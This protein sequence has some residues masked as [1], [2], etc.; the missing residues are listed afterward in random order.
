ML[1]AYIDWLAGTAL[2]FWAESGFDRSTGRFHERLDLS[3]RPLAVP[4]RAMVQARQIYV[5]A[6]AAELGW[7]PT[8]GALAEQA[9]TSMLRDFGDGDPAA[10]FAFS[11]D[12]LSGAIISATR[13]AY[14]HAFV[15]FALAWLYRRTRDDA[16]LQQVDRTFAFLDGV[17]LD[18]VHGGLFDAAPI[19]D[20]SKR[21]NPLMHLL[22]AC[23]FLES[24]RPDRGYL[25]RARGIVDVLR[26]RLFRNP[27]GVLLEYF[28]EDWRPHPDGAKAEVWEPGHHMEWVWLLAKFARLA[29]GAIDPAAGAL[30]ARAVTHGVAANG[31]LYDEVD[32][33]W[34]PIK[35]SHRLWPH[36][37]AIKAAVTRGDTTTA[38]RMATALLT[39][40]V[41]KPFASGWIDQFDPDGRPT[42]DYVPASSL[43]HLF[44]AGA[45]AASACNLRPRVP[46]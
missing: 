35:P 31:L 19:T 22:E 9:L 3:G 18:P 17:L 44:L 7:L 33:Q 4:H 23:L 11:I 21:Q 25:D 29:G 20:R 10:S 14:T 36:T 39:C 28:A 37:E 15:L 40:F 6:H 1:Q 38:D 24:A 30:Y 2:P 32:L 41:A 5:F 45:E 34:R 46:S 8:A 13:D 42:V 12:P 27:P 26:A 16:L 43:Y